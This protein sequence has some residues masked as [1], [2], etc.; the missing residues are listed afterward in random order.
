VVTAQ[1]VAEK[2]QL[3]EL[4]LRRKRLQ[5]SVNLTRALGGG[6]DSTANLESKNP[7]VVMK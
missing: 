6:F 4:N 3:D 1:A 7:T 2:V 5:A